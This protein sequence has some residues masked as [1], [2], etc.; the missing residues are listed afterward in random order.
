MVT[1]LRER[2]IQQ[3]FMRRVVSPSLGREHR[4]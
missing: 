3:S 1:V 4:G 2:L